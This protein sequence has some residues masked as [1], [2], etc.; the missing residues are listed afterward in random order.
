MSPP[1]SSL[2]EVRGPMWR[3]GSA[4]V[5][6]LTGVFCKAF[7]HGLNKVETRGLDNFLRILDERKGDGRK[8]GLITACNHISV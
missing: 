7:M 3:V 6:G 2:P 5:M 1:A 4:A 8:R